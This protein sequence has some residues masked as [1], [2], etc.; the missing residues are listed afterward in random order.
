[1][2]QSTD[3]VGHNLMLIFLSSSS[4][5]GLT[6]LQY[7]DMSNGIG[8]GIRRRHINQQA[9]DDLYNLTKLD[10]SYTPWSRNITNEK[11]W[12]SLRK[13]KN[14]KARRQYF[15]TQS[16]FLKQT[17]FIIILCL[18]PYCELLT[19]KLLNT[20]RFINLLKSYTISSFTL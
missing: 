3:T 19:K 7:L 8:T 17:D 9:F 13:L 1:M 11:L 10:I 5:S 16:L 15:L 20:T 6:M 12:T 2:A 4:F 14:L 18:E